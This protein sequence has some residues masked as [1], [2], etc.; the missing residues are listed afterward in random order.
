MSAS[1]RHARAE[2]AAVCG[3]AGLGVGA[4]MAGDTIGRSVARR[5][6][7]GWHR[8][9]ARGNVRAEM[10]TFPRLTTA[11][12][13]ARIPYANAAPFYALWSEAPFAVRNLVP[14]ELGRE[15][16]SGAV[17][18][19]LM[20]TGDFLRLRDRFEAL[21]PA[22]GVATRGPVQSVVL[23]SRRPADQLAGAMISVT[24]E[25]STSIRLL[26][27]LFDVRRGFAGTRYVRGLEPAQAD[28]LLVIGD[29]AMR[30]RDH[31]PE[32]FT[33]VLDLG[34]DWL[35][36]TGLPFVFA[37]WAVRSRLD[38]ALKRELGAY[39][40]ASLAAGLASLPEVARQQS[41]PGWSAEETEAYLRRFR[42]RLGAE[43]LE[44]LRRFEMLVA[45]HGLAALD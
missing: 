5:T 6:R 7:A 19:G 20:A 32:G 40:E 38:P 35:E 28:G 45:E 39:L 25:T 43:E 3:T 14:R 12:T 41:E 1:V 23:Y 27:L 30:M 33:H 22:M 24:P 4:I 36:W 2:G 15:A 16:E 11:T 44:G 21:E 8:G 13:A 18:I 26:H 34:A 17:D 9:S 42:Y 10:S 29:R 31:R 37:I